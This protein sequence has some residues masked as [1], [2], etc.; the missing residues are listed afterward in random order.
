MKYKTIKGA[1]GKDNYTE[2]LLYYKCITIKVV[3]NIQNGRTVKQQKVKIVTNPF[4]CNG[5]LIPVYKRVYHEYPSDGT[6]LA[7]SQKAF[8]GCLDKYK[9][10]MLDENGVG[11]VNHIQMRNCKQTNTSLLKIYNAHN[12]PRFFELDPK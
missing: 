10:E 4:D 1:V 6:V 3:Q 8:P 9:H 12:L 11:N 2:E 7:Y 5:E